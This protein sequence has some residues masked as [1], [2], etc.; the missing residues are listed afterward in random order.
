[1]AR[2]DDQKLSTIKAE[3]RCWIEDFRKA[4]NDLKK[5]RGIGA[6]E[7]DIQHVMNL[8]GFGGVTPDEFLRAR[9][10]EEIGRVVLKLRRLDHAVSANLLAGQIYG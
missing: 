6:N 4:Q 7:T 2:K 1:M 9:T 10:E 3:L 8:M 5:L